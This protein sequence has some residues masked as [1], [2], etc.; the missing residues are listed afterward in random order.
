LAQLVEVAVAAQ[1]RQQVDEV[2]SHN[3]GDVH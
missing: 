3:R 2:V 1:E